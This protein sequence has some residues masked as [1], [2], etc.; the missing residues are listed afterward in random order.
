M[1]L[2]PE[3]RG[4]I[5]SVKLN[6]LLK[7][8]KE[9]SA[10]LTKKDNKLYSGSSLKLS[11]SMS[12]IN[13]IPI[14]PIH[15]SHDCFGFSLSDYENSDGFI[16]PEKG[17]SP[18]GN[19]LSENISSQSLDTDDKWRTANQHLNEPVVSNIAANQITIQDPTR[20]NI[21]MTISLPIIALDLTYDIKEKHHLELAIKLLEVNI[22]SRAFDKEILLDLN[23]FSI[24]DSFRHSRQSF[25]VY[26]PEDYGNLIH[27]SYR[28]MNSKDSP[29]FTKYATEVKVDFTQLVLNTDVNTINHLKPFFDVL[30]AKSPPLDNEVVDI[31]SPS[32]PAKSVE[33][34]KFNPDVPS[35]MLIVASLGRLTLDMLRVPKLS[36]FGTALDESFTIEMSKMTINIEMKDLMK[37]DMNLVSFRI[38][39][40]RITS[41]DYEF[42]TIICPITDNYFSDSVK[43]QDYFGVE[44]DKILSLLQI[45]YSQESKSHSYITLTVSNIASF[46]SLD[47]ALDLM[48]IA[49]ANFFALLGLFAGPPNNSNNQK[50]QESRKEAA[51]MKSP[52]SSTQNNTNCSTMNIIAKINNPKLVLLEDPTIRES[53][54]I[55]GAC[56][57][58]VHYT[59]E[60]RTSV[61]NNIISNDLYESIHLTVSKN[62]ASVIKNMLNWS[63]QSILDPFDIEIHLKRK[64]TNGNVVYNHMHVEIENVD[65]RI[66]FND[67]VLAKNILGRR[68]LTEGSKSDNNKTEDE[69][70]VVS[71]VTESVKEANKNEIPLLINIGLNSLSVVA[72][73]DFNSQNI[74]VLKLL[75]DD[76]KFYVEGDYHSNLTGDGS[77]QVKVDFYNTFLYAYEPLL[78]HWKPTL[79]IV[80]VDAVNI[81]EI[82]CDHTMQVTL[83]GALLDSLLRSYSLFFYQN[84]IIS[85][86]FSSHSDITVF[87]LL[88][89]NI[90]V[91]IVDSV[92]QASLIVIDPSSSG[93]LVKLEHINKKIFKNKFDQIPSA[94]DVHF[95]GPLTDERQPILNLQFNSSQPKAFNLQSKIISSKNDE[96]NSRVYKD[97]NLFQ[98]SSADSVNILEPIIEEVYENSRYEPLSGSWIP[99][100]LFGDPFQWT[101]ASGT[102]RKDISSIELPSNKWIWQ[103]KWDI[104]L[105]GIIGITHSCHIKCYHVFIYRKR[106]RW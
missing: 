78:D 23:E 17:T 56:N 12:S 58:E 84:D 73:N 35:G 99:P 46:I 55:V 16:T 32:S 68:T 92:T 38:L 83:S 49:A 51:S 82:K 106:N 100:F 72:I 2:K 69:I 11:N 28:N 87:N 22:I 102:I 54:A 91:E 53:Q 65:S 96:S 29:Y 60:G 77:L 97:M 79:N 10:M 90:G 86:K 24:K 61:V 81:L 74:P 21:S 47:T 42:R 71:K 5:D 40:R 18:R 37:A 9:V 67:M 26:T 30:L 44:S 76:M 94:V 89:D 85:T 14:D 88:G 52:N 15:S 45:V 8:L 33:S 6:R 93:E 41:K 64:S 19:N 3:L 63:P 59:R 27:I 4:A 105:N 101:D 70:E 50:L 75:V 36:S 66:S 103:D 80:T 39:D 57:I 62:E 20:R 25:L 104:D 48:Y 34:F 7:V 1:D 43:S 13:N 31:D 98:L 95:L